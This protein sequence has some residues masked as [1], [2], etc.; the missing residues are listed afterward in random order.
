MIASQERLS[1]GLLGGFRVHCSCRGDLEV[2]QGRPQRLLAYLLLHSD[3][4]ST[5]RRLAF[6]FW[7]DTSER[8]A[9]NNL[10]TLLH[11]FRDTFPELGQF[12][13]LESETLAWRQSNMRLDVEDFKQ[14]LAGAEKARRAG[15]LHGEAQGLSSAAGIYAGELLPDYYDDWV[16]APREQLRLAYLDVLERLAVLGFEQQKYEEAEAH[17]RTLL[18]VDAF[19]ES[20]YRLQMQVRL[21]RG[22]RTGA[23]RTYHGY[24]GLLRRELGVDPDPETQ[25]LHQHLLRIDEAQPADELRPQPQVNE[26]PVIGR[27]AEWR[28]LVTRWQEALVGRP[29]GVLLTGEAG[30][31]CTRLAESF[32]AF[33]R[34]RGSK[35]ARAQCYAASRDLA[36]AP[37]VQWLRG[38]TL[39]ERLQHAPRTLTARIMPL[40]GPAVEESPVLDGADAA[41]TQHLL[42]DA[43]ANTL[44]PKGSAPSVF[45]IDDLHLCDAWTLNWLAYAI[46]SVEAPFLVVATAR[47]E[48][49]QND[50][51]LM[52]LRA[53][54]QARGLWHELGIRPLSMNATADLAE[55]VTGTPLS[56]TAARC[57]H[58]ITGGNPLFV[59][60]ILRAGPDKTRELERAVESCSRD[61]CE[62]CFEHIRL[63][64][65]LDAIMRERL[66]RL[67]EP[68]RALA[69]AAAVI[70]RPFSIDVAA[71]AT[72]LSDE[73]SLGALDELWHRHVLREQETEQYDFS[74]ELLR[75]AVYRNL[76]PLRRKTLH[77]E[78]ARAL[79][80]ISSHAT[81]E[82]AAQLAHHWSAAGQPARAAELWLAAGDQQRLLNADEEAAR[83]YGR[84][85]EAFVALGEQER[86][87]RT[88]MKSGLAFQAADNFDEATTA[89]D[90][91]FPL[92]HQS[93]PLRSPVL[94]HARSV[95]HT[96]WSEPISLNPATGIDVATSA[97]ISQLYSGLASHGPEFEVT[98]DVAAGWEVQ[99]AGKRYLVHLR[100][101]VHWSDGA[102]VTAHDFEFAWKR[103]LDPQLMSA[104]AQL[105]DDIKGARAYHSGAA[106]DAGTVAVK[107]LDDATLVVDLEAPSPYFPHLLAHAATLPLPRHVVGLGHSSEPKTG[108]L[109]TNGPFSLRSWQ[110]GRSMRFE[111]N[112]WYHGRW[113]GNLQEVM[114]AL[115][116]EPRVALQLYG[117]GDL[118]V[119]RLGSDCS[120][121]D[122]ALI[123]QHHA[124][125]FMS[126][127]LLETWHIG[128]DTSQPPFVDPRVRRA[129]ALTCDRV[130]LAHGVL[131][132]LFSPATGGFVP[133]GLPGHSP[134]IGLPYDA[135]AGRQLL[136]EAGYPGGEGFPQV[137]LFSESSSAHVVA[138]LAAEWRAQLGIAIGTEVLPRSRFVHRMQTERLDMHYTA[139][140]A[141][142]PDPD[143]FVRGGLRWQRS[144]W[145]D[146]QYDAILHGAHAAVNSR[147]RL[148]HYMAADRLLV[149]SVG[150][151]PVVYSRVH[152]LMKPHV[153][154]YRFSGLRP[155]YWPDVIIGD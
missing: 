6:A 60:E 25:A 78:I 94:A 51:N 34:E 53:S 149:S 128:F 66:E 107:A 113:H 24:A 93:R 44:A 27:D 46:R 90:K 91:A 45:L 52:T 38:G 103:L 16:N 124:G 133:P 153:R 18:S 114:L 98:P 140:H 1:F 101:D 23:L 71:R 49:L 154:R 122:L 61:D 17:L 144:R 57:L 39:T 95:L 74:H 67:S 86:A 22:N 3:T 68:A 70:G 32:I 13:T 19:R 85:A 97:V 102:P 87:A 5:R 64:P 59:V 152:L 100:R 126:G 54:L 84:A 112:P 130:R 15:D 106:T 79:E 21:A 108:A 2:R 121:A 110:P 81:P 62:L 56:P 33:T 77:R 29:S 134:N 131:K 76:N 111:R 30:V 92:W 96:H 135:A 88:F 47:S 50:P 43:L 143:S 129:F 65:R 73:A 119:V 41:L 7:P 28:Y 123:Q 40:M 116:V 36:Y 148:A 72:G 69:Q 55:R 125:E 117:A 138:F 75:T 10:R 150:I 136:S 42:W 104:N 80:A 137:T 8:Q 115:D 26:A 147:E 99:E 89:Y 63:T 4:M 20:G 145:Q 35:T 127:S 155:W 141:D 31:G 82:S 118:D 109:V 14:A 132:G 151:L 83:Y 58:R 105:L 9:L 142:Y 48:A 146:G 37:I 139:W 11:R 12:L 120:M